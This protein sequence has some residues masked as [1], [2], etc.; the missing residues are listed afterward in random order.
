MF[1][2]R[3]FKPGWPSANELAKHPFLTVNLWSFTQ[4]GSS[5]LLGTTRVYLHSITGE[6][7]SHWHG[8]SLN[9]CVG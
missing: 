3:S 1:G 5:T 9:V 4:G 8:P 6:L 7:P 2:C